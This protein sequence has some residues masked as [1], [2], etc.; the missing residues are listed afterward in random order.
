MS[1]S[2]LIVLLADLAA[3]TPP[4]VRAEAPEQ[5]SIR[6]TQSGWGHREA[7]LTIKRAPG[8]GFSDGTRA[9]DESLLRALV[10]V[11]TDA[12]VKALDARQ[13]GVDLAALRREAERLGKDYGG[14]TGARFV[15]RACDPKN[16]QALAD[17]MLQS[18]WTDDYPAVE[19][20]ITLRDGAHVTLTSRAQTPLMLPWQVT[21][22]KRDARSFD[23]RIGRAIAALL[24]A[25]FLNRERIGGDELAAQLADTASGMWRE[26]LASA[27]AEEEHGGELA[28]LKRRFHVERDHVGS[29]MG[30]NSSMKDEVWNGAVVRSGGDRIDYDLWLTARKQGLASVEPFLRDADGLERRVQALPWL[31]RYLKAHP[32]ARATIQYRDDRSLG[33]YAQ[34]TI[35]E[36]LRRDGHAALATAIAPQLDRSIGL[37]VE[38]ENRFAIWIVLPDGRALLHFSGSPGPAGLPLDHT[39]GVVMP[40]GTPSPSR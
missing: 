3:V 35:L 16:L 5:V 31:V 6:V 1:F 22:A 8:G 27:H 23:P 28:A 21:R 10:G 37:Y 15:E 17:A 7:A 2:L 9:I 20:D 14:R 38:N 36:D 25:G 4:A 40:D 12:P 26:E 19:I 34:A 32:H 33:A 18:A 39:S 13:L 24:P 11:A 30:F 29:I